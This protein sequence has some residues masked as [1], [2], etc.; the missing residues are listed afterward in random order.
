M[1]RIRS[2]QPE[3]WRPSREDEAFALRHGMNP[4][5][6]AHALRH[7]RQAASDADGSAMWHDWVLRH[8]IEAPVI[9]PLF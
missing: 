9:F 1:A 6:V 5:G 2:V 3:G 8:A 7:H 4:N